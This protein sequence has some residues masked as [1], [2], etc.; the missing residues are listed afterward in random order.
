MSPRRKRMVVIGLLVL[1]M[2]L[3][4]KRDKVSKSSTN[5]RMR[6]ACTPINAKYCFCSDALRF[7]V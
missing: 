4:S 6:S 5:T 3:P 1:G 7:S 2:G